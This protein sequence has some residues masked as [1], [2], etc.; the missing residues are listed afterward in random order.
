MGTTVATNALLERK[1]ERTALLVTSGF[2]DVLQIGNQSRP[3]MFDLAIRR[4]E[5]LYSDVFEVDERV[6]LESC[7]DSDLRSRK[8]TSPAALGT[9]AGVS[10]EAVQI[11]KPLDVEGTR[12]HLQRL[13]DD[14]FRSVAVCL[15]HSYVFPFHETHIGKLAEE[16]GFD[17]ITLSH[18][19]SQRSKLVPRGNSAV[20][21]GYLTPSINQYLRQFSASFPD[22][23]KQGST[24][25]EFMQSDG[26]LVPASVLRGLHS[27]LSG[28]AGGV[29]G[30]SQTCYDKVSK[31]PVI[32]FDMG[33]TSTDV[34]RF[35]GQLD[36]IFETTTAGISIHV[37]QLNVNTIAAGGGSILAWRDGLMSVG[38]ESASSHPGPACYRKG[39]PLTVTDANLALGRLLPEHFPSVFG[40]NEDQPLDSEIVVT[41]FKELTEVI[42]RDTNRSLTWA[43]VADG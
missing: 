15:M 39:G 5:P 32:G 36:H 12:S 4:P 17:Q 42:N 24:R 29:V 41:K 20:V 30:Y 38:P 13:Y 1:G 33:G 28:P 7:A 14:G 25:L 2:K 22:L 35:D 19:V 6:V 3:Y 43:E 23:E 31:T 37:P 27:I 11:I 40:P 21:D 34:S 16:I 10:G 9:V 26:G 18:D 8:L